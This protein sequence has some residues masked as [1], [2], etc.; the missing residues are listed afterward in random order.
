MKPCGSRKNDILG[1]NTVLR[2]YPIKEG[3]AFLISTLTYPAMQHASKL[4]TSRITGMLIYFNSLPDDK[5]LY[6]SELKEIA[7]AI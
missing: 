2:N 3:D 1:V 7:D 4:P 6:W 5:I